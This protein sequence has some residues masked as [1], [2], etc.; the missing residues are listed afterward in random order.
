MLVCRKKCCVC[1][2]QR[3]EVLD[4]N[5]CKEVFVGK[6]FGDDEDE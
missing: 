2:I 5:E 4:I 1:D 6:R 3:E